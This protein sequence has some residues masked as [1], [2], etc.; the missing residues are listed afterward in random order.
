[1]TES[2]GDFP[3]VVALTSR[4]AL[5]PSPSPRTGEGSMALTPGPSPRTGEGRME[6][7]L[8]GEVDAFGGSGG[9]DDGAGVGVDQGGEV[10]GGV[11]D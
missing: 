3:V 10:V 1:L 4:I 5:T 8:D 9:P 2:R 6:G 7:A 11:F